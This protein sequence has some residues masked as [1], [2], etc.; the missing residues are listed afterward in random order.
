MVE[1]ASGGHRRRVYAALLLLWLLP[2]LMRAGITLAH[3]ARYRRGQRL[4][5]ALLYST[6]WGLP[7]LFSAILLALRPV[8]RIGAIERWSW[9]PSEYG[10]EL[11]AG[12]IAALDVAFWWF[13]LVRL[14]ATTP[15]DTRGRVCAFFAV[16]APLITAAASAAWWFGLDAALQALFTSWKLHFRATPTQR[17]PRKPPPSQGDHR[18]AILGVRVS[19]GAPCPTRQSRFS[20]SAVI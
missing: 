19:E 6:A 3:H 13:W 7:L 12:L 8:G 16:G 15:A 1:S 20:T 18:G 14:G 11:A 2:V 10:F 17:D 4:T 9:Y 5:A